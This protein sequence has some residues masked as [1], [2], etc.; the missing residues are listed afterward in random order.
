MISCKTILLGYTT[1]LP[2]IQRF[3][4]FLMLDMEH[5]RGFLCRGLGKL[6]E[7]ADLIYFQIYIDTVLG[8]SVKESKKSQA[9]LSS[10]VRIRAERDPLL[11][12]ADDRPFS[13]AS[14]KYTLS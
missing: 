2:T 3:A 14:R 6:V 11:S 10:R 9:I 5:T 4:T 13:Y 12:V 7:N 8:C 1:Q